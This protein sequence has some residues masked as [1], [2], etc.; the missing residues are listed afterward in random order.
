MAA[1]HLGLKATIVMPLATP[2]IK[3]QNVKALGAS[4]LLHGNDFDEAKVECQRLA[5]V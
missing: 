4:I 3:W 2:P 5:N 1:K